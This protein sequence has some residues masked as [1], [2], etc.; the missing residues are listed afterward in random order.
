MGTVAVSSVAV[1]EASLVV[2]YQTSE[3][4]IAKLAEECLGITF[5]TPANYEA[6]RVAIG[7]LRSLRTAVEK[8]R[9]DLKAEILE[10][11]RNVDAVAKHF[12]GLIE[13]IEDPLVAAKKA[14]DDA[15]ARRKIEAERAELIALEAQQKADREAA[16]AK[17]K[18]ERESEEARLA[19]ERERLAVERVRQEEANR[20]IAEEQR[21]ERER[22]DAQQAEIRR[23]QEAIEAEKREVARVAAE[24]ERA[25]RLERERV[26]AEEAALVEA[27]RLEALKPEIERVHAFAD[28]ILAFAAA[29]PQFESVECRRAIEWAT[30]S[31]EKTAVGLKAFKG[32]VGP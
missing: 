32:K 2:E 13:A 21:A 4:Q 16:E 25:E 29:A 30:K 14:V 5:D 18:V 27:A 26:A 8:R 20:K 11:G 7:K 12:T 28:Q 24:R 6:G 17:A 31:L 15:E 22:L 10:K 3:E 1:V 19:I 9:K 23:Q